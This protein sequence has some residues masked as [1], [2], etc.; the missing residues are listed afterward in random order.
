MISTIN[1]IARDAHAHAVAA[2]FY[3]QPD[4]ARLFALIHS[5]LSEAIQAERMAL[6]DYHVDYEVYNAEGMP[7]A[8]HAVGAAVELADFVLRLLDF[9]AWRGI[10]LS[11][12]PRLVPE[13]RDLPR[14]VN[15][16]HE[17]VCAIAHEAGVMDKFAEGERGPMQ[18]TIATLIGVCVETV[19]TWADA[20]ALDIWGIIAEKMAFNATRPRMHGREY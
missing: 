1:E 6:G 14:M 7:I 20:R 9:A 19:E 2:G 8:R 17:Q 11:L 3:E 18:S 13:Y 10:R 12:R 5:E 16:M 4:P 15:V